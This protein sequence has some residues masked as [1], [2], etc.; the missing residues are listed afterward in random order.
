MIANYDSVSVYEASNVLRGIAEEE[1]VI[2]SN[3]DEALAFLEAKGWDAVAQKVAGYIE[4]NESRWNIVTGLRTPEELLVIKDRFIDAHIVLIDA[5]ATVARFERHIKRARDQDL[6]TF[7]AFRDEDEKQRRFGMYS[8]VANDV[9]ES[10]I[11][12]E[13]SI[14]QY[15]KKIDELL[16]EVAAAS[17]A[18]LPSKEPQFGELHRCLSALQKI[19][20][21]ASCEEIHDETA[22]FGAPVRNL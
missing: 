15:R 17:T 20:Q 6:M 12:N 21:P 13:G 14:E 19:G 9:A 3:S 18:G 10:S 5:D 7:Q 8:R 22:R 2:P 1:G 11:K 16:N 4:M